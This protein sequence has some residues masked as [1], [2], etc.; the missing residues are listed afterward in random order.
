MQ[1]DVPP[2]TEINPDHLML[3]AARGGAGR[4]ALWPIRTART[5]GLV[6]ESR[7]APGLG[8]EKIFVATLSSFGA[9]YPGVPS[10]D[11]G[12]CDSVHRRGGREAGIR[13]AEDPRPVGGHGGRPG[14][15]HHQCPH[16]PGRGHRRAHRSGI[17]R[18][19][20]AGDSGG[21]HRGHERLCPAGGSQGAAPDARR[22]IEVDLHPDRPQPRLDIERA[23]HTVTVGRGR[24]RPLLDLRFVLLSH[25]TV[26][27]PRAAVQNAELLVARGRWADANRAGREWPDEPAVQ[28]LAAARVTKW[29][30]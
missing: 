25:N 23:G 11:S 30:P 27:G 15:D 18:L 12:Q 9:G 28:T 29:S 14:A 10:L 2:L 22:V 13:T 20:Q 5:A 16:Q 24:P 17:A 7:P 21:G 8:P 4:A 1:A 19:C 3:L 26:R 6:V